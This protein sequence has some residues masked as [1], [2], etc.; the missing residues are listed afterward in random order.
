MRAL[1][2]ATEKHLGQAIVIENRPGVGG[3]LAPVQMAATAKPDGHTVA[4]IP[5]TVFR[6]PFARKTTF[7]PAN[8]LTYIINLS[9]YTF[10]VVV[11][12]KSPW[13]TF[14]E[15]LEDAKTNP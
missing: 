11:S 13:S 14:G 6:Y 1:A 4:Q 15:L 3:A 8:D 2:R 12:A 7:D 9:G 10:G 5:L